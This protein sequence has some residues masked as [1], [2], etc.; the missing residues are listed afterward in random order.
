MSKKIQMIPPDFKV[1]E[2]SVIARSAFAEDFYDWN[3]V[4]LNLPKIHESWTGKEV[5]IGVI[6]TGFFVEHPDFGNNITSAS[7]VGGNS[8]DVNGH[9]THVL[10]TIGMQKNGKGLVGVAPD[11]TFFAAKVLDDNGFGSPNSVADGIRWCV[12]NGCHIINGSLGMSAYNTEIANVI[13]YAVSKGVICVF[14]SG[15]D[16]ASKI[17]FPSSLKDVISVGA[18]DYKKLLAWFSNTGINLDI[19]AP[20]VEIKSAWPNG[21]YKNAQGTSMAAPHVSGV[22]ALYFEF[23]KDIH[24]RFPTLSE[25]KS[26]MYLH[27]EDLGTEGKDKETGHGLIT[28]EF[29]DYKEDDKDP[30]KEEEP[31]PPVND[32]CFDGF[33][34]GTAYLIL[35]LILLFG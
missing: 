7:F 13:E 11:A 26:W 21:N 2:N 3:L 4:M 24:E 5:K 17:S 9:G 10:G 23:F 18:I 16:D 8:N 22:I 30:P 15:N 33:A 1:D 14:A 34:H 32:G 29:M 25:V 6:D 20:G 28:T 35:I 19:V 31:Q 27:S 12:D